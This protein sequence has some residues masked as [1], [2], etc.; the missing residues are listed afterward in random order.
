[1]QT[2]P[3]DKPLVAHVVVAL[4]DNEF[5]GIVPVPAG[6]ATARDPKSNLYWGAMYGVRSYFRGE[7]ATGSRV[8]ACASRAMHACST[9][10]CFDARRHAKRQATRSVA[11]SRG[12]ERAG[13]SPRPSG[14]SSSSIAAN[15]S[16]RIR[17]R[18]PRI[19]RP[20]GAAHVMAFVGHN[21]LMDFAA[22]VLPRARRRSFPPHASVVLACM[23]DSLFC[24]RCCVQHSAPLLTTTGLMAPEAYTLDAALIRPGSQ[25]RTPAAT[26]DRR[27]RAHMPATSD[28]PS[29]C[30]A[31][32][33]HT[34]IGRRPLIHPGRVPTSPSAVLPDAD[35]LIDLIEVF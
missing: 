17:G 7:P 19:R 3:A 6:S 21:G 1:M 11:G 27:R 5:Q 18:R 32:V 13:T 8:A 14:T 24:S 9:A 22:P 10:C 15:T 12:L 29:G 30:P 2:S 33:S 4:C 34:A 23:S 26:F 35:Q 28:P 20:A 25:V 16:R 31:A